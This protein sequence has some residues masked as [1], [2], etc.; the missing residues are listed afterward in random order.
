MR[1][2]NAVSA[3][4]GVI[5]MVAS[6]VAIAAT[7]YVY[8]AGQ[9]GYSSVLRGELED[10]DMFIESISNNNTRYEEL[11]DY[12]FADNNSVLVAF[13]VTNNGATVTGHFETKTFERINRTF[14][15]E[16]RAYGLDI[17]KAT[18]WQD[19]ELETRSFLFENVAKQNISYLFKIRFISENGI[20]TFPDYIFEQS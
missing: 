17:V 5:L 9:P 16:F 4:I 18:I 8:V 7:V 12:S 2:K 19:I 10:I 11:F 20:Y 3:V 6:T 15:D 1:N 13:N 14:Y